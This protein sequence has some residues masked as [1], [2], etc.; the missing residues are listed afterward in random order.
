M[1]ARQQG[2]EQQRREEEAMA[3]EVA[4]RTKARLGQP[5]FRWHASRPQ[6]RTASALAACFLLAGKSV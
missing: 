4:M 6:V 5:G 1:K 3:E 2:L